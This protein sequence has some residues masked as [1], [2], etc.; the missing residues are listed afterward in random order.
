[1]S[2]NPIEL[3]RAAELMADYP[4][5]WFLCGGWAVDAWFG[6]PTR[7]HADVDIAVVHDDQA[8]LYEY[9]S[10]WDLI[11]H[12]PNVPDDSPDR[13][14]GRRLDL[15]AHIHANDPAMHGVEL[16]IQ[17]NATI[18]GRWVCCEDPTITHD[19]SGPTISPWQLPTAPPELVLFYKA[20]GNLDPDQLGQLRP[21]DEQDFLVL[22]PRLTPSQHDWLHDALGQAH[23]NHPWTA[24]LTA[25]N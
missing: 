19:L 21:H 6:K 25:T 16:D 2:L 23:P 15:P 17:L 14:N 11:G 9:L 13:W 20:G 8:A 12:D 3:T 1:M 7:P 24:H 5:P 18:D 10:G 4:Y 22:A